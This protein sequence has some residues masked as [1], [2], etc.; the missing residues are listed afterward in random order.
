MIL[1]ALLFV[2]MISTGTAKEITE[3]E[4][5]ASILRHLP[6]I[7]EAQLKVEAAGGDVTAGKGAFDTKLKAKHRNHLEK[8]YDNEY[9]EVSLE[10]LLPVSG[11]GLHAGHRQGTGL[12]A[13]YEGKYDTSPA[14]EIFAGLSLPLLRNRSVDDS[15]LQLQLSRIDKE[16][17]ER[18]L[19]IKKN[20]Y[21]YKGLSL[22]RKWVMYYQK[23]K[24]IDD[25]INIAVSRQEMLQKRYN[26]GD[27]ERIK[28]TDNERSI[29]KR[30]EELVK[31]KIEFRKVSL[32]LGLYFRDENGQI[33]DLSEDVPKI[34]NEA[35]NAF[36]RPIE[37][38][39]L[40][41]L[42][43]IDLELERNKKQNEFYS[44]QKLPLLN[45]QA[46]AYKELSQRYP[47]DPEF[48]HLNLVFEYPLENRKAEGKTVSSVY[49]G[50]AL[51]KK[52]EWLENEFLNLFKQTKEIAL[53]NLER[54]KI[55]SQ[56]LEN[57]RKISD[58]ERKRWS[59]GDSDLFIVALREQETTDVEIKLISTRYELEQAILDS[60]LYAS[61][62]DE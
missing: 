39:K 18:E 27:V 37:T 54:S 3:E 45:L 36:I 1:Y 59:R 24:V 61:V 11:I 53:L 49:K 13:A 30:R 57:A 7:Q 32:E 41:Q 42:R 31:A 48:L 25:L 17:S 46:T 23:L 19:T 62:I 14:G 34:T 26:A 2:A 20:L 10:K 38:A 5:K 6:L 50:M 12:F 55:I 35:P 28:I 44:N 47:F 22:Y 21:V 29:L 33:R 4:V 8:K 16:I 58:A 51:T 40:P 43:I 15:R 56:E 9:T 52:K 60:K